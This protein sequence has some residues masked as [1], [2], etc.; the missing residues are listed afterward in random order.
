M[1]LSDIVNQSESTDGILN[2][3]QTR[4][5]AKE[6]RRMSEQLSMVRMELNRAIADPQFPSIMKP[7][8]EALKAFVE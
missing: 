4:F 2:P 3:S 6:S 7:W 8:V 5:L 1:N